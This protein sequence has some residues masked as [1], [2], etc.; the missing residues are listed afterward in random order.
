VGELLA[1]IEVAMTE[2]I[3]INPVNSLLFISD[4]DGG[5]PPVPARGPMILS[6]PSCISFRCFPEQDG[7]TE[8]VL[9]DVA[10]VNPGG[11]PAFEGD[12]ETP[13]RVLV[14]S[15]VELEPVLDLNV[16]G[17]RTHVRIWLSHPQWPERVMIGVG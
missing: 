17:T 7:A 16:A 6:T 13:N 9:G 4:L 8:V 3:K 5:S 10:E 14:V 12:L 11:E 1:A 15:T 2:S